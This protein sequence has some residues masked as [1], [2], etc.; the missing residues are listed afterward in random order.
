MSESHQA[1]EISLGEVQGEAK[2]ETGEPLLAK[3]TVREMKAERV[4]QS[5]WFSLLSVVPPLA[6]HDGPPGEQSI[7]TDTGVRPPPP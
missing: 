1:S 7:N 5:E 4:D 2:I 3:S 6:G